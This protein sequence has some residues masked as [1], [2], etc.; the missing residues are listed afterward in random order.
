MGP[1]QTYFY[2]VLLGG[3]GIA[4]WLLLIGLTLRYVVRGLRTGEQP[5]TF[6][7]IG[8]AA[9]VALA[10]VVLGTIGALLS[11]APAAGRGS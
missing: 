9:L 6:L 3:I 2:L 7:L 10:F 11:I 1:L 8:G 4:V 5:L